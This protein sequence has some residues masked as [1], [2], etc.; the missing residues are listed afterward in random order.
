MS[1]S[2]SV[3]IASDLS[4]A[5]YADLENGC[6]IDGYML[7]SHRQQSDGFRGQVWEST[8]DPGNFIIAFGGTGGD[9]SLT[10]IIGDIE[11]DISLGSG[12]LSSQFS[13]AINFYNN[14]LASNTTVSSVSV[15]GHSLGGALERDFLS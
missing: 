9:G 7:V 2:T 12:S 4:A 11:T 8:G 10:D 15:T 6:T 5:A 1:S 14:F 3:Q 13:E